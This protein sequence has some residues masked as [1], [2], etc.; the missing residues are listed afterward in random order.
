MYEPNPSNFSRSNEDL[1]SSPFDSF[2][3]ST[4]MP[5]SSLATPSFTSPFRTDSDFVNR[6]PSSLRRSY[7]AL[8]DF[9]DMHQN[10][11]TSRPYPPEQQQQQQ[12]QQPYYRSTYQTQ[13]QPQSQKQQQQ[14]PTYVNS[15]YTN[16]NIVYTNEFGAPMDHYQANN[17]QGTANNMR[18][19]NLIPSS[20]LSHS[21]LFRHLEKKTF[22][23]FLYIATQGVVDSIR[24]CVFVTCLSSQTAS[25]KRKHIS[26]S[27]LR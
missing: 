9:G 4:Q 3:H 5:Y 23:S 10:F 12:Q 18:K 19:Y 13:H 26:I 11:P 15:T 24:K 2:R 7:D 27:L 6:Y 1:F 21:H 22:F 16:P 20:F 14:Q 17:F 25:S 8:N